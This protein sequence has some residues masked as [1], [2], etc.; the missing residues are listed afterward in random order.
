MPYLDKRSGRYFWGQVDLRAK[1]G[2]CPKMSF[3]R[4]DDAQA[5]EDRVR[6]A[7]NRGGPEAVASV[8]AEAGIAAAPA[9]SRNCL[10][11]SFMA[12][13]HE[14]TARAGVPC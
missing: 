4:W 9:A 6:H 10:R 3:D 12:T 8:L 2:G 14:L 11:R 7:W 13:L 5:F 1:G